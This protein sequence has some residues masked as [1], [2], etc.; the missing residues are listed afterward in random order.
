MRIGLSKVDITPRV[1]VE[2]CGFGPFLN[3]F[4][5]LCSLSLGILNC[6]LYGLFRVFGFFFYCLLLLFYLLAEFLLDIVN[7]VLNLPRV[8]FIT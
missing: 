3:R 5:S 1:G 6:I 8:A 7:L 2:L 4:D